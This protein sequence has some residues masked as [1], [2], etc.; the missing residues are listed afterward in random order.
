MGNPS[1]GAT[2]PPWVTLNMARYG[3]LTWR[4]LSAG[5]NAANR[6]NLL[7]QEVHDTLERIESE[8]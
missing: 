3:E 5:V 2:I 4:P 6:R 8:R 1:F 7:H